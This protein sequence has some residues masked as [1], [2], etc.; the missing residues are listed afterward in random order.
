MPRPRGGRRARR[1]ARGV[2]HEDVRFVMTRDGLDA[3]PAPPA[4]VASATPP[5]A[6]RA[7]WASS[8]STLVDG[9]ALD[10]WRR[11]GDN[12]TIMLLRG[13]Q[14]G[15]DL[16]SR[17]CATDSAP[18]PHPPWRRWQG[19]SFMGLPKLQQ[20]GIRGPHSSVR[21]GIAP[22][23]DVRH[24]RAQRWQLALSLAANGFDPDA[25]PPPNPYAKAA[26]EEA[27]ASKR[28]DG[29]LIPCRTSAAI[30][31]TRCRGRTILKM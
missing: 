22:C 7:G 19:P 28:A 23:D 8:T 12:A 21:T 16:P 9:I 13:R 30:T 1:T 24:R 26:A 31:I 15:R 27:R 6:W 29:R 18:D 25:P 11:E 5:T 17:E 14:Q 2:P 4:L 10:V 3:S 20:V